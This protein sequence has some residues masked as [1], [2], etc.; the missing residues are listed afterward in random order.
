MITFFSILL[1][2]LG[3]NVL[4]LIFSLKSNSQ[5]SKKPFQKTSK[6]TVPKLY[7]EQYSDSEYKKAV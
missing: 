6:N 4:L 7:S 5:N 3:I 1:A 2:L